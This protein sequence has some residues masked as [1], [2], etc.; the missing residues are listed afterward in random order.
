EQAALP[1]VNP[2]EMGQPTL[3]AAVEAMSEIPEYR[4]AFQKAFGRAPNG[5]DLLRAIASYERTLLS[6][7]SPFD[8][9]MNGDKNAIDDAAKRG[10]AL[11]NGQARCNRCHAVSQTLPNL[12]NFNDNDF[13]NIGIGIIR[14]HVVPLAREAEKKI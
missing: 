4:K 7:D 14:H 1:I 12:T 11:F 3:A 6:F 13:H 9:F 8:R 2:I 10:W 5:P